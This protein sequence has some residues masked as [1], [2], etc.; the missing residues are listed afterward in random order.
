MVYG[1][2]MVNCLILIFVQIKY[3]LKSVDPELA[4]SEVLLT[5]MMK[6]YTLFILSFSHVLCVLTTLRRTNQ[7]LCVLVAASMVIIK[8]RLSVIFMQH[9]DY[10]DHCVL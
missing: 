9:N 2:L 6:C 3:R 7:Y 10:N 4:V 5:T 8:S 1:L